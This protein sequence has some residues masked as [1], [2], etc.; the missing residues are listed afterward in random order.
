MIEPRTVIAP[1]SK[2]T[3]DYVFHELTRSICPVCR[4]PIDAQ[5]L[6][7]E[8]KVIMRKRCPDHGEVE[9]LIYGDAEAYLRL[10]RFN[11]PGRF[12]CPLARRWSMAVP[13]TAGSAPI[14]SNT[15]AW[16][17]SR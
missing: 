3:A 12:P 5:I 9:A 15:S 16:A 11:K 10:A 2:H 7:R 13:T 4:W 8:N 17:L 1:R 14:T 6:L